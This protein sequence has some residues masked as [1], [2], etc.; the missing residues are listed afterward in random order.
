M[1]APEVEVIMKVR[2]VIMT[3]IKEGEPL[4]KDS[5]KFKQGVDVFEALAHVDK[6]I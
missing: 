1:G 6:A 5:N 2:N 3:W 4:R